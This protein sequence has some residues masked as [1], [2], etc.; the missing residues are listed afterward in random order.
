MIASIA[1]DEPK[2]SAI[3]ETR[4]VAPGPTVASH[5]PMRPVILLYASAAQAAPR[6]SR[7]ST[8]SIP[9]VSRMPP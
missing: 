9:G 1:T 3:P 7:I 5:T 4:F 6:S 2:A 8:C